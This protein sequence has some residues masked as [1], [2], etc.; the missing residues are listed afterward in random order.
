MGR[1]GGHTGIVRRESG[2]LIQPFPWEEIGTFSEGLAP[3]R[4]PHTRFGFIDVAGRLVIPARFDDVDRFRHGL[5]K[6]AA[7]DT[8]GYVSATGAWVWSGRFYGFRSR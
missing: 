2:T 1:V 7:G 3:V 5:C 6:V 4:S 8:L